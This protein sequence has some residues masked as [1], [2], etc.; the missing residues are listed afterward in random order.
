MTDL[1]KNQREFRGGAGGLVVD[2]HG[3]PPITQKALFALTANASIY[4]ANIALLGLFSR[5]NDTT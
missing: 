4:R 1:R 3:W 2:Q 5:T